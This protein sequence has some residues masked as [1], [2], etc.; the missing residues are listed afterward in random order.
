[1]TD[2]IESPRDKLG[3]QIAIIREAEDR[4]H[5]R[6]KISRRNE[7]SGP[8][9]VERGANTPDIRRH[10]RKR[11]SQCLDQDLWH[12]FRDGDVNECVSV[13][14]D[15]QQLGPK[16]HESTQSYQM[17]N[18]ELGR[19]LL[20]D[21]FERSRADPGEPVS[22]RMSALQVAERFNEQEGVLLEVDAPDRKQLDL[23]VP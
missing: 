19:P 7:K 17:P 1:M 5:E 14:I 8:T 18:L 3:P 2:E 9:V 11:G 6:R 4:L 16:R 21:L 15:L 20:D 12:A 22:S 10:R 13:S 23:P